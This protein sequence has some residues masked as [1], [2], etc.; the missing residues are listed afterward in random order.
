MIEEQSAG[1]YGVELAL[2]GRKAIVTGGSRGLGK[3][4]ARALAREGVDLALVARGRQA[5]EETA[6]AIAAEFGV[7]VHPVACDVRSREAV[8]AMAREAVGALG[9][10]D[11]LVSSASDPGGSPTATG[12]IETVVDEDLIADF[13]TKYVGALRCSRAVLPHMQKAGWGRIVMISGG[14]AR[15]PGNLSGGARNAAMVHLSRTLAR[16]FG[17]DGITVNCIHPGRTRTE[18]TPGQLAARAAE[19]GITPEEVE[20][21][22]FA[23]GSPRA[24]AIGRMVDASEIAEIVTFLASEPARVVTGELISPN[25]GDGDWVY[26]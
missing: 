6:G 4:I 20:R 7:R 10:V 16:R 21:R 11:I 13:D 26:Y 12:P 25:G 8:D 18:R 14:N 15:R 9:G 19:L 3:A 5:L 17:R 2:K 24:N 23:E 1:G 22:E